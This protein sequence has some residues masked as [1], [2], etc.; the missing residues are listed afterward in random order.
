M[1]VMSY[2]WVPL[3]PEYAAKI[4]QSLKTG[5]LLVFEHMMDESAGEQRPAP[6]LPR[7]NELLKVFGALRIL[8]YEDTRGDADWSWRPERL[9]RLVAER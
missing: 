3:T 1:V 8:R 9:A 5:G 6:W 2:S 7:P 4:M